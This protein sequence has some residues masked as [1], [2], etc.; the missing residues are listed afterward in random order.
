MEGMELASFQ[1]IAAV[2]GARSS[3]MEAL[4]EAR[5]GNFETA[6]AKIEEAGTFLAEAHKGHTGL[7][8][9][10]AQGEQLQFSLLFMHAEDQLMT[11]ITLRDIAVE[12][13]EMHKKIG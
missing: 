5:E 6:E 13:I 8:Q 3:V 9:K 10:E 11:T 4:R 1:I 12:M 7:I 2:G